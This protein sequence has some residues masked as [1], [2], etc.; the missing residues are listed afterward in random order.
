VQIRPLQA[1]ARA[2]KA[3]STRQTQ[4]ANTSGHD[5]LMAGGPK[6]A[7]HAW[8]LAR[9]GHAASFLKPFDVKT[10]LLYCPYWARSYAHDIC[11]VFPQ[12]RIFLE[13]LHSEIVP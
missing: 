3:A 4:D 11:G 9:H 13:V 5:V 6:V 12:A 7:I 1:A 8:T 2:A 10:L